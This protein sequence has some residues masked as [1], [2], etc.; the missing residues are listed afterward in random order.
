[1]IVFNSAEAQAVFKQ[2]V[3]YCK[4]QCSTNLGALIRSFILYSKHV[5]H[6]KDN[7]ELTL[8]YHIINL[9][10]HSPTATPAFFIKLKVLRG[11]M[12]ARIN[13]FIATFERKQI[14]LL[15]KYLDVLNKALDQKLLTV[16][17]YLRYYI[18]PT[19]ELNGPSI[20]Q[21]PLLNTSVT[22]L[23]HLTFLATGNLAAWLPGMSKLFSAMLQQNKNPI[24]LDGNTHL[25]SMMKTLTRE[26]LAKGLMNQE[27]SSL[28]HT[29]PDRL[30]II[31]LEYALQLAND[32]DLEYYLSKLAALLGPMSHEWLF[33]EFA[34]LPTVKLI[35][36]E[37]GL[38]RT[39][40]A[41]YAKHLINS[42]GETAAIDILLTHTKI[43]FPFRKT[44]LQ[45][46]HPFAATLLQLASD[47]TSTI[48]SALTQ[49]EC[50]RRA[51][52]F[53]TYQQRFHVTTAEGE[54]LIP[55]V[56]HAKTSGLNK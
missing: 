16:N 15:Q 44:I 49:I 4:N 9:P 28:I 13:P 10:D 40:L 8:L 33:R 20:L 52:L 39:S 1:M 41:L 17:H 5:T 6:A 48:T 35:S 51:N 18:I 42:F 22:L 29:T 54:R 25:G 32:F 45:Q 2:L 37:F 19:T 31:A 24:L 55:K 46:Q 11:L 47:D 27:N 36:T 21:T 38:K 14:F 26:A 56:D 53:P 30:G 34:N 12:Q 23:Q 3:K 7:N 43:Q 50:Y